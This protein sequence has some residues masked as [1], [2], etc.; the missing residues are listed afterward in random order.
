MSSKYIRSWSMPEESQVRKGRE[1][2]RRGRE[3]ERKTSVL[4]KRQGRSPMNPLIMEQGSQQSG[5]VILGGEAF[6]AQAC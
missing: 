2:R 3:T 5:R 6:G 1:E 4:G